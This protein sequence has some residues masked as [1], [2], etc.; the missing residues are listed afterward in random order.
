MTRA[1]KIVTWAPVDAT[2]LPD[3]TA[4]GV[5]LVADLERRE[6]LELLGERLRIRREG[7]YAGIDVFLFL[8]YFFTSRLGIGIKTF[9]GRTRGHNVA[10]AALAGRRN[11][12]SSTA[13]ARAL[14]AV[15]PESMRPLYPWLLFD[16]AGGEAVV[17]HPS[18]RSRDATGKDWHIFDFDGTVHAIRHRAL[19]EGDD[20]PEGHRRSGS[21]SAPGYPGRKR[22][23]VQVYRATLQHSGSGL[24]LYASMAPGNGDHRA[25]L[26]G[27]LKVVVATCARLEHPLERALFRIDG[28]YGWVPDFTACRE[29]K[30]PFCTRLTRPELFQQPD[31]LQR[32]TEADWAFVPDSGGGPRRSAAELGMVTV[33]AGDGVLR[34]DGTPYEPI[35]VRVVVSRFERAKAQRGRVIEAWQYELFVIDSGADVWPAAEAIALYFGRTAEENRFAQEDKELVLDRIFSYNLAGQEFATHIGLMVWNL[36]IARG[37]ELDCPPNVVPEQTPRVARSDPRPVPPATAA[38]APEPVPPEPDADTVASVASMPDPTGAR[39]QVIALLGGLDWQKLLAGRP[40]W[41]WLPGSGELRCPDNQALAASF[42]DLVNA[43]PGRARVYFTG[44]AGAC[45]GCAFR[46]GCFG[47][48]KPRATKMINVTVDS[49]QAEPLDKLLKALPRQSRMRPRVMPAVRSNAPQRKWKGLPIR[50][51]TIEPG[52][53]AAAVALFLPAAARRIFSEAALNLTTHV[54][55]EL[56]PARHRPRLVAPTEAARRHGRLTWTDH[57]ARY[58]LPEDARVVVTYA[59]PPILAGILAG[60]PSALA[61]QK[62][63]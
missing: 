13:M 14:D 7:G 12:A 28:A 62:C 47:S 24:W 46:R 34:D 9:W 41:R 20:L 1:K 8:L 45:D 27:A 49:A 44:Q 35:E 40:N 33:H 23:D 30:V 56:P 57:V 60:N 10:L 37:F 61:R 50:E 48:S 38:P 16:V 19:P 29:H 36:R 2:R 26:A 63:G 58:A 52:P 25:D 15:D 11:L 31:V 6:L 21:M 3:W 51:T 54:H 22:G 42:T 18:V 32:L 43:P 4:E 53:L 55:V 17:R 39:E 59:G 5:A